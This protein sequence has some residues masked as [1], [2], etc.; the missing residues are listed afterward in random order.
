MSQAEAT[1]KAADAARVAA[2]EEAA[3][4]RSWAEEQLSDAK[5]AVARAMSAAQAAAISV[6]NVESE[7]LSTNV[8]A[9]NQ[10]AESLETQVKMH[11]ALKAAN[12]APV[13]TTP[14][15]KKR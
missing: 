7:T 15:G 10:V 11:D 9:A 3:T 12:N 8:A 6:G 4:Y 1:Q 5:E 13:A 14:A 2:V